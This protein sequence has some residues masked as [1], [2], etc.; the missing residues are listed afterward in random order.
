MPAPITVSTAF[1][2]T[3]ASRPSGAIACWGRN[4]VGQLG[5]GTTTESH[6]PVAV[7]GFTDSVQPA[8]KTYDAWASSCGLHASGQASCWGHR[9]HGQLGDGSGNGGNTPTKKT[10]VNL[11]DA[12]QLSAGDDHVCA[13]RR[14]GSVACW[15][16]KGHGRLG[17]GTTSGYSDVPLT[18]PGITSAIQVSAGDRHTCVVLATGGVLGW[19]DRGRGRVGDGSTSSNALVPVAVPGIANAAQVSAGREHTCVV[20]LDGTARC[21]G[22]NDDDRIGDGSSTS[23]D[24]L[25]PAVVSGLTDAVQIAAGAQHT[26]AVRQGGGVVCWGRRSDGRVGNGGSTSGT[27]PT[28]V[29]V[30]ILTD[31]VSV[32]AGDRHTCAATLGSAVFCWGHGTDGKLGDGATSS[33]TE[34]VQVVMLP[35]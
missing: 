9:E 28:P 10:V 29:A 5:N 22:N 25:T 30:S 7:V 2:H 13:V 6:V 31:A 21:W 3:C 14:T 19:G 11:A 15:G 12:V 17:N 18:V 34:P 20:L 23:G 26:C 8:T 24:Q 1:F 33:R 32:D 27:S 16:D 35:P 4:L